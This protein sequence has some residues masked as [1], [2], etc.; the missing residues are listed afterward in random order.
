M[1]H[2]KQKK[3]KRRIGEENQFG[4]TIQGSEESKNRGREE[5]K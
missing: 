2:R 4:K 3:K 1:R 5:R